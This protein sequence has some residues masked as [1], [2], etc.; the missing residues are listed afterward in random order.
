MRGT[1]DGVL[2]ARRDSYRIWLIDK[3]GTLRRVAGDLAA[4]K[5]SGDGGPALLA[6]LGADFSFNVV[7][8]GSLM[9][10]MASPR[11][12]GRAQSPIRISLPVLE[13]R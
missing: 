7:P 13:S 3:E 8:D 11:G 9:P 2:F 12:A 10:Y 5:G 4:A 6:G 1:A